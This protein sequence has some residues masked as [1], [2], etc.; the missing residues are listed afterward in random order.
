M[1]TK[2]TETP[3]T[4]G[5]GWPTPVVPTPAPKKTRLSREPRGVVKKIRDAKEAD[6]TGVTK[7]KFRGFKHF[8]LHRPTEKWESV[9]SLVDLVKER[10]SF[11]N[12]LGVAHVRV[13]K[14]TNSILSGVNIQRLLHVYRA[15]YIDAWSSIRTSFKNDHPETMLGVIIDLLKSRHYDAVEKIINGYMPPDM[16]KGLAMMTMMV[17]SMACGVPVAIDFK[18]DIDKRSAVPVALTFGV[19]DRS[20]KSYFL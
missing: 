3:K 15:K 8:T 12:F 1:S 9:L 13:T 14:N 7:H 16:R 2:K 18:H 11:K 6:E 17:F 4:F 19:G 10:S 20:E 5:T